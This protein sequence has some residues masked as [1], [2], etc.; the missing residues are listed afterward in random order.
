MLPSP[1]HRPRRPRRQLLRLSSGLCL[2]LSGLCRPRDLV[3]GRFCRDP[4]HLSPGDLPR[5]QRP[6]VRPSGVP[7]PVSGNL[8]RRARLSIF[9]HGRRDRWP[10]PRVLPEHLVLR[11]LRWRV[12]RPRVRWFLRIPRWKDEF[13]L[14]LLPRRPLARRHRVPRCPP[15]RRLR[16]FRDNPFIAEPFAPD[17]LW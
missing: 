7:L 10:I 14:P 6:L 11:A 15:V 12:S 2:R 8:L 17:S 4:A 5:L 16:R 3:P 13:G 9:S 1:L